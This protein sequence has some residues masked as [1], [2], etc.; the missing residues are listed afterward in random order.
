MIVYPVPVQVT[1]AKVQLAI[2]ETAK[3]AVPTIRQ[4]RLAVIDA[5]VHAEQASLLDLKT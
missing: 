2:D 1:Q 5:E 3:A 4:D